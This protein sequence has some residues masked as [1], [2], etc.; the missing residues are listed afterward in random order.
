MNRDKIKSLI[1]EMTLEEKAGLC[2]GADV[3]HLKSVPRL[4]IGG[5]MVSDGPHGLR[6]QRAESDHL[7]INGSIKA[8]CFP[9]ACATAASFDRELLFR[10]GDMLG[11]ECIAEGVSVLLGPAINI[12]RTP[13]CGRNF[14]YFS[15]DP[16]LSG[17]LS[18]EYVKGVQKNGVGTSVKHF[19]ANNQETDRM[20]V[21]ADMNERAFREIYLPA[22]EKT[23]KEARPYTI[24]CSYNRIDGEYA[25]Q[26]KR[27]LTD[28]LRKEWGFD[29]FVMSDWGAVVNRVKAL[30]AGL[31]LEMPGG[32][33][34]TDKEIEEAVKNGSLDEKILDEAVYRILTVSE[35][36]LAEEE[37]AA[38][39]DLEEG[40]AEAVRI[41]RECIVLLK[42]EDDVL[43]LKSENK[44]VFIGEFAKAPRYQGGGSSHINIYKNTS[45]AETAAEY[46]NISYERGYSLTD[47]GEN[48]ALLAG[49]VKAAKESDVAVIF[50]GLPDSYESEGYD[51][52][53]LRLPESHDRLVEKVAEVQS[54]TVVVLHNG[55]PVEMPWIEKVKGILEVYLGGE[56]MGEATA[57]ALYGKVNPSGKLSETFPLKLSDTPAYLNFPGDNRRCSYSEGIFVGYR[58]YDKKEMPVLF[59]FGHGLSYTRFEYRDLV[60]KVAADGT[61]RARVTV[62]NVGGRFGKETVQ[63]YVGHVGKVSAP[64]R[65]LKGF[66]KLALSPEEE[67]TAEFILDKRAFAYYNEEI[68]DWLVEG[69]EYSI[70]IGASSRDIRLTQIVTLVSESKAKK[71][72]LD[73]TLG[74]L[75]E[76][77][78][79][80]PFVEARIQALMQKSGGGSGAVLG[81]AAEERTLLRLA[82]GV[83]LRGLISIMKL[84]RAQMEEIINKLNGAMGK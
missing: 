53:H 2:S 37:S 64:V 54:N 63:L 21:S 10:L 30:A 39:M 35:K 75:Y 22:F 56:G 26:N 71:V 28:I 67:K 83:P 70:E 38:G 32:D 6:T 9:A 61:V 65:Q 50:I 62:K 82:S 33:T 27:L 69:G 13:L 78:M 74:E 43:P 29:G 68:G 8:I 73:T 5:K 47:E 52:E 14:E 25:S 45:A 1:S 11:R 55:S 44:V 24:M 59:P 49:A 84:T 3:W 7:G 19:A 18:A 57:D 15:E 51:R 31:D 42:N 60:A 40:H 79:T 34:S 4:G 48:E 81:I 16:Y 72:T 41:A 17:E 58:Y 46:G 76:N 12:K 36:C 20:V 23:V 80:R 77:P 66:E